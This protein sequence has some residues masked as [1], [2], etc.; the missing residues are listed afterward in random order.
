MCATLCCVYIKG[1]VCFLLKTQFVSL[2]V[3]CSLVFFSK[4]HVNQHLLP[5]CMLLQFSL[6]FFFC[7]FC[8]IFLLVFLLFLQF[9]LNFIF[10]VSGTT[11]IECGFCSCQKQFYTQH[12]IISYKQK[13]KKRIFFLEFF[14]STNKKHKN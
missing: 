4:K 1:F 12:Y 9:F 14:S 5:S 6:R 7:Y 8:C 13:R 2:I 11:S 10:V 3:F